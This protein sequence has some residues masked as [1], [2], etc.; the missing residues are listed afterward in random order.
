MILFAI[1]GVMSINPDQGLTSFD[2]FEDHW[3]STRS[4]S[5]QWSYRD[6]IIGTDFSESDC[7]EGPTWWFQVSR[8]LLVL[9][10]LS[11]GSLGRVTWL[12]KF[13]QDYT[14]LTFLHKFNSS[15]VSSR[16]MYTWFR[17]YLVVY[18]TS[19]KLNLAASR[20]SFGRCWP[21]GCSTYLDCH[22]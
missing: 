18:F 15:S 7:S 12:M 19:V 3:T 11:W 10:D 8:V 4:C 16:T 9:H 17:P 22:N 6:L 2:W 21:S 13:L 20:S 5:V 14:G 1:S